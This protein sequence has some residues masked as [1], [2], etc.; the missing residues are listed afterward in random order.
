MGKETMAN[1]IFS[2]KLKKRYS[3]LEVVK[4]AKKH[5]DEK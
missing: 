1:K 4:P 5:T 3:G 2:L